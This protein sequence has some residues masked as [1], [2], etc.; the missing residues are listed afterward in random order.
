MEK[1][2]K[3][4][5]HQISLPLTEISGFNN[6]III[7]LKFRMQE[8]LRMVQCGVPAFYGITAIPA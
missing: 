2:I 6:S 7:K 4:S 5:S 1:N 3:L 8:A